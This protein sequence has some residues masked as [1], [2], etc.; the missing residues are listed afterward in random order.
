M[1]YVYVPLA[2]WLDHFDRCPSDRGAAG[3]ARLIRVSGRRAFICGTEDQLKEL[4]ADAEYY[5]DPDNMDEC[6]ENL[7]KS[8]ARTLAALKTQHIND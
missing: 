1:K 5:A 2:F 8:A 4:H 6:P 7:R 3:L